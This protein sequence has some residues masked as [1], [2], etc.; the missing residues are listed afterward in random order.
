[1]KE[2]KNWV[3]PEF[4]CEEVVSTQSGFYPKTGVENTQYHT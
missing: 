1:M 2:K 3:K 4:T